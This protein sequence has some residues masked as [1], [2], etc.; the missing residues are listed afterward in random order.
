[1][2][3]RRV[4]IWK[5][6]QPLFATNSGV[7][8][9][10]KRLLCSTLRARSSMA[11]KG[12]LTS[13][14]GGGGGGIF[15][16]V[17]LWAEALI[18][19]V[20]RLVAPEVSP[21]AQHDLQ[22]VALVQRRED[23]QQQQDDPQAS[24]QLQTSIIGA[25]LPH[26]TSRRLPSSTQS[27]HAIRSLRGGGSEFGE[28]EEGR[29]GK[30]GGKE[31]RNVGLRGGAEKKKMAAKDPLDVTPTTSVLILGGYP[32]KTGHTQHRLA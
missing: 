24:S 31:R 11:Q 14:G 28:R 26:L 22:V 1:M 10:I 9:M 32:T 18:L 15:S 19:T 2:E 20:L 4:S 3:W 23:A 12:S 7:K 8:T 29:N 17:G 30:E 6:L 21:V 16:A 27:C 25:L 13:A 5:M